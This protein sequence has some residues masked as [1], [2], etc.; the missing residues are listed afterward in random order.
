MAASSC[1]SRVTTSNASTQTQCPPDSGLRWPAGSTTNVCATSRQPHLGK[2]HLLVLR[3]ARK[4][5]HDGLERAVDVDVGHAGPFVAIADPADA[6]SRER[7]TRSR[8]RTPSRAWRLPPLWNARRVGV[9]GPAVGDRRGVLLD[10]RWRPG[11][12]EPA[13]AGPAEARSIRYASVYEPGNSGIA[14]QPIVAAVH[15]PRA[16]AAH[17]GPGCPPVAAE[18]PAPVMRQPSDFRAIE[19]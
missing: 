11:C 14:R 1:S 19:P 16:V 8:A 18:R 12:S 4:R 6:G 13:I 17:A 10:A 5:V 9:P 15:E 2:Q 7:E 3:Q